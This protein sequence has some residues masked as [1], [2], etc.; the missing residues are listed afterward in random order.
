MASRAPDIDSMDPL[1]RSLKN[2]LVSD[3]LGRNA[4]K[5]ESREWVESVLSDPTSFIVPV[6]GQ[7]SLFYKKPQPRAAMFS[8]PEVREK[9]IPDILIYLGN[10][11]GKNYFAAS[12]YDTLG[13]QQWEDLGEHLSFESLW[14]TGALIDQFEA[15][16]LAYAR[17]MCYWHQRTRFCGSCG[18]PTHTKRAG[19]MRICTNQECKEIYF[20]RTDPAVIVLVYDGEYCLLGNKAGW[21]E[22]QY[23][24]IAGFVEPGETIEQA[25]VREV[26]EESGVEVNS[27]EYHSS[28]PW[29]FPGSVMVGFHA[30]AGSRE[31]TLHDGE[32]KDARWFSRGEIIS[33]QGGTGWLRLPSRISIARR[34]VEDWA[35]QHR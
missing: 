5:R 15:S 23:S 6:R 7:E 31:V 8:A 33:A 3:L 29:P 10:H 16:L 9:I 20:P 25:V 1:T 32:L 12:V 14:G 22:N 35:E 34:L 4:L 13:A 28:Q 27:L 17:G 18:N 2:G 30:G 11:Q 19:H 21:P 26:R 24:T